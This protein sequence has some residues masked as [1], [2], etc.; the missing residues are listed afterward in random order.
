MKKVILFTCHE[1][2]RTGAPVFLLELLDWL[3]NNTAMS[4]CTL[5]LRGGPL[6]DRFAAASPTIV[7]DEIVKRRG[8]PESL[9]NYLELP[10]RLA[11]RPKDDPAQ[12]ATRIIREKLSA[13]NIDL[14]CMN[15]IGSALLLDCVEHLSCPKMTFV[16]ELETSICNW[17]GVQPFNRL[18]DASS[19]L[20]ACSRA[21]A[22]NLTENHAIPA[23][24]VITIPEFLPDS[25]CCQRGINHS[26]LRDQ[27]KIGADAF[28]VAGCGQVSL[29][30]GA[31]LFVDLAKEILLRN[32]PKSI[33]FVW[34][35][36]IHDNRLMTWLKHDIAGLGIKDYLHFIGET[37]T[38]I[39]YLAE[40]DIFAM[41]SR[42]DPFPIVNLEV[43]YL[44][45]PIV[46]FADSGGS[47]EFIEDDCG[48]V[49]PY[50]DVHAMAD[51]IVSLIHD[52]NLRRSLGQNAHRKVMN[53]Y[54]RERIAPRILEI[55][56]RFI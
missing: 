31:D 47:I 40:I 41:T 27:F 12:R 9:T 19:Q 10:R 33:H 34:I 37:D 5:F 20:V 36:G 50:I 21:V 17:I 24:K 56:H 49:V 2:S 46:A 32:L 26:P 8:S 43:A 4:S 55:I 28:V 22:S 53:T 39:A 11:G 3:H 51:K 38:P 42:E 18:V 1:A 6:L 25:A 14:V 30:K 54:T 52:S 15:S 16:H 35:G 44:G 13:L 23:G 48:Y 45:K 7:L 29:R